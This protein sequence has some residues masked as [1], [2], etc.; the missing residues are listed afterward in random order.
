MKII[1]A[2]LHRF[3]SDG[4]TGEMARKVGRHNSMD[5]LRRV[6]RELGMVHGEEYIGFVKSVVPERYWEKVFF[7][8]ANRVYGLG[9]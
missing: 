8:N 9:L 1:D 6:Y 7:G 3:P 4:R 2:H 5:H